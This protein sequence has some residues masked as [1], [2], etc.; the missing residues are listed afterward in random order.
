MA[1]PTY[2]KYYVVQALACFDS[3]VVVA[4]AV[5]AEFVPTRRAGQMLSQRL[6]TLFADIRST[7][8]QGSGSS[9]V[10]H[11][12]IG[13]P[14]TATT[15]ALAGRGRVAIGSIVVIRAGLIDNIGSGE[16]EPSGGH[17][18]TVDKHIVSGDI[19]RLVTG[20]E[21]G[22]IRDIKR[23]AQSPHRRPPMRVI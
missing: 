5:K 18:S 10:S 6:H 3:P 16:W 15:N 17:P 13:K 14:V 4:R 2:D 1:N 19:R 23:L 12:R 11:R 22:G 8:L 9:A 20:E 7:I 21:Q